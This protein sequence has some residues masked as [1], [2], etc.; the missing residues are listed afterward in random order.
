MTECAP[1]HA[2]LSARSVW[3]DVARVL[4]M[5][6]IVPLHQYLGGEADNLQ[7]AANGS[8]CAFFFLS[9]YFQQ[10]GTWASSFKR[11]G[12]LYLCYYAWA[13]VSYLLNMKLAWPNLEEMEAMLYCGGAGGV[14][15]FLRSLCV[16]VLF[17]AIFARLNDV[18]K[19]ITLFV[20]FFACVSSTIQDQPHIFKHLE[21]SAFVFCLGIYAQRMPLPSLGGALLPFRKGINIAVSLAAL[22]IFCTLLARAYTAGPLLPHKAILLIAMAVAWVLLVLSYAAEQYLPSLAHSIAKCGPAAVLVYVIHHPIILVYS[23]AWC[24][25]SGSPPSVWFDLAFICLLF[26][27]CCYV[28]QHLR[29]KN[30]WTDIFLF[31]R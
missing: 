8:L 24:K 6:F 25:C 18:Y 28:T 9:G 16:M 4:A 11:A 21:V 29:G 15:W 2:P 7:F 22:L 1:F 19:L 30:R 31:A 3:V 20:L 12:I 27:F 17:G 14:Y 10:K 5:L 26:P 23:T 13:L